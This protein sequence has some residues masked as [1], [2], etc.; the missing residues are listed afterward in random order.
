MGSFQVFLGYVYTATHECVLFNHKQYV[1]A[2]QILLWTFHSPYFFFT[3]LSQL[4]FCSSWYC[5]HRHLHYQTVAAIVFHKCCGSRV[6]SFSALWVTSSK[7][8]PWEYGFSMKLP[9][10]VVTGYGHRAISRNSTHSL[11]SPLPTRVLFSVVTVTASML[12]LKCI[13]MLGREW[14]K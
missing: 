11:P 4:L 13:V 14:W 2:F 8:K 12:V 6:F 5:C 10:Q 1:W 3:F 7:H 9:G